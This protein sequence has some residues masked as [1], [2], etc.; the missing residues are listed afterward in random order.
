MGLLDNRLRKLEL[1]NNQEILLDLQHMPTLDLT[2]AIVDTQCR[3]MPSFNHV[4]LRAT[5]RD[6]TCLD[7]HRCR[8]VWMVSTHGSPAMTL[9][10]IDGLNRKLAARQIHELL[11]D[12]LTNL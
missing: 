12:Y 7:F 6:G 4:G 8:T 1:K 10:Q 3:E 5:F 11:E 9:P 2:F